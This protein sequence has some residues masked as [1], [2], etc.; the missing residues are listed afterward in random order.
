MRHPIPNRAGSV[1]PLPYASAMDRPPPEVVRHYE[2][3]QEGRRITEGLGQLEL[4]RTQEVLGRYL[5]AP[6]SSILDVGGATGVHAEWLAFRGH[7]VHVVDLM[8]H[9]VESEPSLL[10]LSAHLIAVTQSG[11]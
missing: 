6:P 7:N 4:F 11:H 9:H 5:P 1:L 3:I 10:G 2:M 8:P